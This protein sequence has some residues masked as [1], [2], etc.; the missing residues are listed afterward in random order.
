MVPGFFHPVSNRNKIAGKPAVVSPQ[1]G[2]DN[3]LPAKP[4]TDSR[5]RSSRAAF[6]PIFRVPRRLFRCRDRPRTQILRLLVPPNANPFFECPR[7]R[8]QVVP[9]LG[10]VARGGNTADIRT[11]RPWQ[12]AMR[13]TQGRV[14]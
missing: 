2:S 13:G 6:Q 10:C 5:P 12:R 7:A 4:G 3:A 8:E 9:N 11:R 14:Q 1:T